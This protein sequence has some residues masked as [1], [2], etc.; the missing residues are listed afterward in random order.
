[1]ES[2]KNRLELLVRLA[3]AFARNPQVANSFNNAGYHVSDAAND[4][5]D[6]LEKLNDDYFKNNKLDKN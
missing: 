4:T 3:E 6:R 1:M 2:S 5:L